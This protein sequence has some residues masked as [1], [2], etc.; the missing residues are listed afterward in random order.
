V[1]YFTPRIR[2][3]PNIIFSSTLLVLADKMIG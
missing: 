3:G 2:A 1:S